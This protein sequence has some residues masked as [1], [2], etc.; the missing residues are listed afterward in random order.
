MST[1]RVLKWNSPS[2]KETKVNP[3]EVENAFFIFRSPFIN[4]STFQ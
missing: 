2:F 3:A 1:K 4:N